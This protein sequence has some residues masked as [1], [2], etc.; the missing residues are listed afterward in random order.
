MTGLPS[1]EYIRGRVSVVTV[2]HAGHCDCHAELSQWLE[3]LMAE[4]ERLRA[5]SFA[6]PDRR[7]APVEEQM[8]RY[9][10]DT[11]MTAPEIAAARNVSVN[12]VKTQAKSVYRKLGISSRAELRS[13]E[14][15]S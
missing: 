14:V 13:A 3:P 11:D 15:K 12:T 7:L 8:M 4:V 9:L 10:R 2:H 5:I 1:L 6:P